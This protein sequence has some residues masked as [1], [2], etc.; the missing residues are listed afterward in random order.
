[1]NYLQLVQ[2]LMQESG[3][4]G[5]TPTTVSGQTGMV[6]RLVDWV[7]D[8]WVDIQDYRDDWKFLQSSF[9]FN[10]TTLVRDY[11]L[12]DLGITYLNKFELET[13]KIYESSLGLSDQ[14]ALPNIDYIRW[15]RILDIGEI[16]NTKPSYFIINPSNSLTL[17]TAPTDIFT[18]SGKYYLGAT[19]LEDDTDI[20]SFPTQYHR[21]IVYR[22]LWY[23]GI[24]IS[25]LEVSTG[26]DVKYQQILNKLQKNQLPSRKIKQ[27]PLA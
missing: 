4:S 24:F 5:A 26:A 22:A 21:A 11:S 3:I 6:K 9:S 12:T 20:P 13:F 8:A 25:S 10:T 23:Y 1:L 16:E 14:W 15:S 17:D 7:N 27:R 18:V 19:E 2:K